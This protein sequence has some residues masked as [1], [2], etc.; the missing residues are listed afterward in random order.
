MAGCRQ[1]PGFDAGLEQAG[2]EG[3][4]V[5]SDDLQRVVGLSER[6]DRAEAWRGTNACDQHAG[7]KLMQH[8]AGLQASR[9]RPSRRSNA[10]ISGA[11]RASSM[12]R[13]LASMGGTCTGA[14]PGGG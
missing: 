11:K 7:G 4:E 9:E 5:R 8:H 10:S 14:A 1:E 13:V 3:V 6:A 2:G 12:A